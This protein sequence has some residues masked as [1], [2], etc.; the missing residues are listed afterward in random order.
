MLRFLPTFT[1]AQHLRMMVSPAAAPCLSC[2][3]TKTNNPLRCIPHYRASKRAVISP[4]NPL[5]TYP[6]TNKSAS[7]TEAS[8]DGKSFVIA[9][10]ECELDGRYTLSLR[11]IL[12]GQ[13]AHM[14]PPLS[15][16]IPGVLSPR[17]DAARRT[18]RSTC[19]CCWPFWSF[20]SSWFVSVSIDR[21]S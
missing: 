2:S 7:A 21:G 1:T 15:S 13:H 11:Q 20:F 6:R 12:D 9:G 5:I 17:K 8:A 18:Q 16:Q 10:R 3:P 4:G 19:A 14:S